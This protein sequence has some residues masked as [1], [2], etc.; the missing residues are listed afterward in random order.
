LIDFF[1]VQNKRIEVEWHFGGHSGHPTLVFLH[2]GLGC[3]SLWKDFPARLAQMTHCNAFV[4]SRLGH[5]RSDSC[6]LPRKI[7][8]M[9]T[10]ALDFLPA[11]LTAA[12]I[13]DHI[14]IG[15]SDGGSMG[16]IYAGGV[17]AHRLKGLITEA[18][19]LF[20]EPVTLDNIRAAKH[21]YLHQDLKNKLERYHG[22]NT[23]NTFW[24]WNTVWLH[25]RFIHWNI[26]KYLKQIAVPVLALQ[27]H[28]DQ[29][30]SPRQLTAMAS[31]VRHCETQLLDN[32]RHTPHQDQQETVLAAMAQF[33]RDCLVS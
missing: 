22:P 25:P 9:H 4:F 27:G 8:F 30:G 17:R 1:W 24:G 26:Q 13:R 2:E 3:V 31:E 11:V 6:P 21:Q 28:Q 15:H 10:E 16:I 12:G 19:H 5:G 32:C 29:Y 14:I 20:C 23:D 18:A 33:I 7:N